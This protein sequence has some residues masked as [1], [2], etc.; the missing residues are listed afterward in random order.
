MNPSIL[1]ILVVFM[2]QTTARELFSTIGLQYSKA[3]YSLS[4]ARGS[5]LLSLFQGTQG[6]FAIVLL[7]FITRIIAKPLGWTA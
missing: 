4:Y 5:A 2:P 3:R 7:P 1:L 6:I